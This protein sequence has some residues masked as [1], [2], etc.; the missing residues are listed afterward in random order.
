MG[1]P[2]W[3]SRDSQ[4]RCSLGSRNEERL[5][6]LASHWCG[7][8]V[9]LVR[10][11]VGAAELVLRAGEPS[12]E[13][14]RIVPSDRHGSLPLFRAPQTSLVQSGALRAGRP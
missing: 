4:A 5:P 3:P 1:A 7:R 9:G 10:T 6:P 2:A 11:P 13:P 8:P 14:S 12:P